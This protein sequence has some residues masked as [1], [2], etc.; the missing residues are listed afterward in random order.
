MGIPANDINYL[1]LVIGYLLLV[2]IA[3]GLAIND[4]KGNAH[5]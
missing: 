4:T 5:E 2:C 1:F 3:S